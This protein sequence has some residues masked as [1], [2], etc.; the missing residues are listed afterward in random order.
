MYQQHPLSSPLPLSLTSELNPQ[1]I[2]E[3][4]LERVLEAFDELVPE[5]LAGILKHGRAGGLFPKGVSCRE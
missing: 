4:S 3:L 1:Q 5:E 2:S